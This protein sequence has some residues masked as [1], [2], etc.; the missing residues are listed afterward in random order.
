[1]NKS[2]RHCGVIESISGCRARIRTLR[3]SACSTCSASDSCG[4]T[5]GKEFHLDIEDERLARHCPGDRVLVEI[6][7]DRGRQAVVVGFGLPLIVFVTTLL[8]A[9]ALVD[10]VVSA[11]VALVAI[12]VYYIIIYAL[13]RVLNRHFAIHLVE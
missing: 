12:V 1:M 9:H 13:R 4:G 2:I 5:H 3:T 11:V 8:A 10:D 7:A 6:S